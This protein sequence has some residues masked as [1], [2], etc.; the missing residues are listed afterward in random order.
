[1]GA[2]LL[3]GRAHGEFDLRLENIHWGVWG[4][5]GKTEQQKEKAVPVIGKS[6]AQ[7]CTEHL[8]WL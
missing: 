2:H 8:M 1:M 4:W 5:K 7:P 3:E 6:M